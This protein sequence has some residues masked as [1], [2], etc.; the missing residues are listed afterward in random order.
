MSSLFLEHLAPFVVT[1]YAIVGVYYSRWLLASCSKGR[2]QRP[3]LF[4]I[5]VAVVAVYASYVAGHAG[6]WTDVFGLDLISAPFRLY[7]GTLAEILRL[8]LGMAIFI[9]T[10]AYTFKSE[11][12]AVVGPDWGWRLLSLDIAAIL[13]LAWIANYHFN[14]SYAPNSLLRETARAVTDGES[15]DVDK[16]KISRVTRRN[17]L[18]LDPEVYAEYEDSQSVDESRQAF[19][20]RMDLSKLI[21]MVDKLTPESRSTLEPFVQTVETDNGNGDASNQDTAVVVDENLRRLVLQRVFDNEFFSHC[22]M[23]YA[24]YGVYSV[25]AFVSIFIPLFWIPTISFPGHWMRM[26]VALRRINPQMRRMAIDSTEAEKLRRHFDRCWNGSFEFVSR[27]AEL[28]LLVAG[29]LGVELAFG[30]RTLTQAGLKLSMIA[31]VSLIILGG[32]ALGV[33]LLVEA[34][35]NRCK[36]AFQG[37]TWPDWLKEKDVNAFLNEIRRNSFIG[38]VASF[39]SGSL[40]IGILFQ[41]L[42]LLGA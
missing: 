31:A 35:R 24:I 40:V 5:A 30:S 21:T 29:F 33:A 18:F 23:P 26:T 27:Y 1:S 2:W 20:T 38:A 12:R 32:V 15:T 39:A 42:R 9:R 41:A 11:T 7:S 13:A 19:V 3:M 6:L 4:G 34:A 14:P 22:Q 10:L 36:A 37:E 25:I 28:P 16:A 8:L 17:P